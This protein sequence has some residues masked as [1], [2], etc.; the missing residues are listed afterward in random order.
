MPPVGEICIP[1]RPRKSC[2]PSGSHGAAPPLAPGNDHSASASARLA[3]EAPAPVKAVAIPALTTSV[4]PI[5]VTTGS[6]DA[7]SH[8]T[9]VSSTLLSSPSASTRSFRELATL[10]SP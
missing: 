6:S 1:A 7:L 4:S 2:R 5:W 3:P 8:Q 10:R 9:F